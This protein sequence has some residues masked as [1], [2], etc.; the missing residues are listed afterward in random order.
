MTVSEEEIHGLVTSSGTSVT[1]VPTPH[2]K[3]PSVNLEC[4]CCHHAMRTPMHRHGDEFL[5][6]DCYFDALHGPVDAEKPT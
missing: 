4:S 1:T 2:E 6:G 5:C 3:S